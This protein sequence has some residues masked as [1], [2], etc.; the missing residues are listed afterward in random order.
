MHKSPT[1]IDRSAR[2]R[3]RITGPD[4]AKLLHNLCTQDIKALGIGA[5]AEAFVTSPQG[6]TLGYILIHAL[7]DSLLVRADPDGLALAEPHFRKYAIFDEVSFD[8]TPG[9]LAELHLL[10]EHV[11]EWLRRR[12]GLVPA[13]DAPLAAVQGD[14]NGQDLVVIRE[15]PAG[16]PGCTLIGAATALEQ[17]VSGLASMPPDRF[18]RLRIQAGT[19]AFGRDITEANLPQEVDR[20]ARAISFTKGCYL[21]QETVARLDALGHVN[22]ILRG[23]RFATSSQPPPAPQSQLFAAGKLVGHVTSSAGCGDEPAIG[24]GYVRTTHARPGTM[25]STAPDESSPS[26]TVVSLPFPET[27]RS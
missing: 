6:K 7:D 19:P 16:V 1:Y 22:K 2:A 14:W 24:L 13:G 10:G 18:E 26:V 25:L 15:S 21:G 4:R 27:A 17:V 9:Q 3:L 5:G 23:L 20:D 11:E 12:L 8:P